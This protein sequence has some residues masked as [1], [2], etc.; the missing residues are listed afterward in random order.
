M[1]FEGGY[2]KAGRGI[3]SAD[4]TDGWVELKKRKN[5][6]PQTTQTPSAARR[7]QMLG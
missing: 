7:T 2:A 1:S 3:K 6:K 4:F 5:F